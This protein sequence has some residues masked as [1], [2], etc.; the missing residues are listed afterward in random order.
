MEKSL[1]QHRHESLAVSGRHCR[2]LPACPL[3]GCGLLSASGESHAVTETPILS[4][5]MLKAVA[6]KALRSRA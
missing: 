3:P 5:R 4:W 1:P 6:P 2:G